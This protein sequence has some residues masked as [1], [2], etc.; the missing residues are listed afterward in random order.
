MQTHTLE[1]PEYGTFQVHHRT[2]DLE[3]MIAVEKDRLLKDYVSR[4]NQINKGGTPLT[5]AD[6]GESTVNFFG[7]LASF[8]QT[9]VEYPDE[10]DP[11][12]FL[13][14]WSRDDA[15]EFLT[16]YLT[17]LTELEGSFRRRVAHHADTPG[18]E[19]VVAAAGSGARQSRTRK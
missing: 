9:V 7:F 2:L 6:V 19:G 17:A 3:L 16:T 4:N 13:T 11:H 1:V 18:T 10:F 14:E 15:M 5:I 8:T 12:T